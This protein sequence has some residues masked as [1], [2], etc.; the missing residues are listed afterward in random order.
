MGRAPI[1]GG[2]Q[3]PLGVLGAGVWGT[4]LAVVM[5]RSGHRVMLWGSDEAR[6]ARLAHERAHTAALPGIRFPD[7]LEI[8]SD[9]QRVCRTASGLMLAVPSGGFR[10]ILRAIVP[11]CDDTTI[12]A[13]AT[14]GLESGTHKRLSE[15]HAEVRPGRPAALLTG[16]TFAREVAAGLPAAMTVASHDVRTAEIVASWIR[17]ERLRVYTSDDVIGAEIGGAVKNVL[18]IA[19]GI[20]DGLGFGANARAAL[21][22]RGLAELLRLGAAV[23]GR[24]ETLIGLSGVGDLVLTCTDDL[25]RNRRVGLALAAERSLGDILGELGQ[26]VEGVASAREVYA[27]AREHHVDMPIIEQVYQVLFA[28]RS[29]QAA[30]TALLNRDPRTEADIPGATP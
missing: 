17:S 25:S 21:I 14:K 29:P 8:E 13:W 3:T 4:A 30:V 10:T 20:S 11:L 24:P 22:T 16:P 19:A 26:A 28:G 12:V 27:L 1:E 2:P 18:A 15:I 9:L 5:A 23:G 7:N 6:M